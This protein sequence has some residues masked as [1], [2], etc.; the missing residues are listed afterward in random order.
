MTTAP[1]AHATDR[2]LTQEEIDGLRTRT[3]AFME[4]DVYPNEGFFHHNHPRKS[5]AGREK[6]KELQAKTK[7][8]G[9]WAPHLPAE[10]GG[11]GIGFM[12]YV[13]MN[14]ILGRSSVAPMAFGSQ[15]PD[16]GNAEIL[17]QFGTKELQDKL[18]EAAR[19]RRDLVVLSR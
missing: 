6:L 5:E 2:K 9:M 7:A 15:A 18:H 17:W 4:S 10:A 8:M 14:E 19:E 13:F 16:S 11:M 12:P 1:H 3:K